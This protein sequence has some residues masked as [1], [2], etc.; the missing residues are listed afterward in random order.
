MTG[1]PPSAPGLKSPRFLILIFSPPH[2][3]GDNMLVVE[4]VGVD[5]DILGS[6][7]LSAEYQQ[8]GFRL[9]TQPL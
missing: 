1:T 5:P 2:C 3:N 6:E 8:G 9:E 7:S 4:N